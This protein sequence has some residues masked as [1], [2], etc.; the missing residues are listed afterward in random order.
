MLEDQASTLQLDLRQLKL[1]G[2]KNYNLLNFVEYLAF[3]KWE[4]SPHFM[5]GNLVC[6]SPSGNFR[7]PIWATVA[8]K[9]PE[10][11]NSKQVIE[12]QFCSEFNSM[13]TAEA[14]MKLNA[15]N[16]STVMVESP[17]YFHSI[18]PVLKSLQSFD[19]HSFPL[20]REIVEAVPNDIY[21]EYI[22]DDTSVDA[23][24]LFDKRR[25]EMDLNELEIQIDQSILDSSQKKALISGLSERL[26]IIQGPPGCG[27][28]F[29][30]IK[31]VQMILSMKPRPKLPILVLTYKNHALD[32]FLKDALKFLSKDEIARIGGRSKDL[33]V[34]KL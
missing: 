12:L 24:C 20:Q 7:D 33:R 10:L 6:L 16:G 28:T 19:M 18:R 31:L 1:S 21:P 3:R 9:D 5:F 27:K 13:S 25:P 15:S 30:G 17:Q 11:L 34:R 29:I 8:D 14:I 26:S 4:N 32:E 22:E 2:E 23:S